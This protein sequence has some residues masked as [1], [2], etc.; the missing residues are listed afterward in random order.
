MS[1]EAREDLTPQSGPTSCPFCG[2]AWT[3][4]DRRGYFNHQKNDCLFSGFRIHHDDRRSID[5]WNRRV[6]QPE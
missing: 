1:I 4:P 6:I 2:A 3:R 5:G